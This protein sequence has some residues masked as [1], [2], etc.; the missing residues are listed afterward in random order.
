[1]TSITMQRGCRRISRLSR[2][3]PVGPAAIISRRR[4]A[5]QPPRSEGNARAAGT[6]EVLSMRGVAER[7]LDEVVT[8]GPLTEETVNVVRATAAVVAEHSLKITEAFYPLMFKNNPEALSF[9]NKTNQVKGA[10]PRALANAIVAFASNIDNLKVLAPAVE[11]MAHRHCAIGV[12]PE[13]YGIVH[14]NLM[15]AIG[16][17][18]GDAVTPEIGMAWSNAVLALGKILIT[19]EE[20]L[21]RIAEA[22]P[23]GWRG[24]ADFVLT[25]REQV[26]EDTVTFEFAPSGGVGDGVAHEA[27]QYLSIRVPGSGVPAPR[28]YTVT[29]P[30]GGG[31]PLQ[32]TTRYVRGVE[33]HPDGEVS[34]YMHTRLAVGEEVSLA[35]P[36]GTFVPSMLGDAEVASVT[37]GIGITPAFAFARHFSGTGRMKGALHVDRSA[38]R[39][40][41]SDKIELAAGVSVECLYGQPRA[42]VA[43]AVAEFARKMG[44]DVHHLVCGPPGFMRVAQAALLEGGAKHVHMELF[45]TGDV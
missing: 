11:K 26:A 33:G 8:Q 7:V 29:S 28:H 22:R 5:A 40:G 36:F 23:G 42:A 39:D 41:L 9:F 21:F 16:E 4:L 20:E 19:T 45:G 43:P 38:A 17:V 37:A 6:G 1:M 3:L 14:K 2:R 35:P 44:P 12:A 25:G 24:Y 34:N 18:L 13:H 32:I 27:G 30:P 31:R 15:L 10:Q